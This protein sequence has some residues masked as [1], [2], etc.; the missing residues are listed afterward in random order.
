VSAVRYRAIDADVPTPTIRSPRMATASA[1]G[2]AESPVQTRALWGEEKREQFDRG[3][4]A[5]EPRPRHGTMQQERSSD[6]TEARDAE[7]EGDKGAHSPPARDQPRERG[8]HGAQ[9][10]NA[11]E[12][13]D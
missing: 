4:L 12:T 6:A 7:P 11:K 10:G 1:Y 3:R 9:C 5:H 2:R 13:H 8:V